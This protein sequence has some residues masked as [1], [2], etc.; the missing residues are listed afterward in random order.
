MHVGSEVWPV[1]S[2]PTLQEWLSMALADVSAAESTVCEDQMI[3][4]PPTH[5]TKWF[6]NIFNST[7]ST[8]WS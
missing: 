7:E 8:S 5:E 3:D 2:N 6:K 1:C 4:G